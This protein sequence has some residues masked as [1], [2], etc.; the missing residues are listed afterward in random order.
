MS[1]N[2]IV[3]R[4]SLKSKDFRKVDNFKMALFAFA[5]AMGE[6]DIFVW[7][8]LKRTTVK[9]VPGDTYPLVIEQLNF[10]ALR[11]YLSE[12]NG[13]NYNASEMS[14]FAFVIGDDF[15]KIYAEFQNYLK[16]INKTNVYDYLYSIAD[17]Q[18]NERKFSQHLIRYGRVCQVCTFMWLLQVIRQVDNNDCNR[19]EI[20]HNI[21]SLAKHCKSS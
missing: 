13:T 12:N 7:N 10:G 19:C 15:G 16:S 17:I 4:N 20:L 6:S 11:E 2:A 1:A 5:Y 3:A 9:L 18:C 21:I 8:V 14:V